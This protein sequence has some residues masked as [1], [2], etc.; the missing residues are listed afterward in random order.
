MGKMYSVLVNVAVE[1]DGRILLIKRGMNEKHEPGKWCIPGG[2]LEFHGDF[3][4]ALEET[5][6]KRS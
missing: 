5:A 6:K 3:F 4:N 2:K 1:K